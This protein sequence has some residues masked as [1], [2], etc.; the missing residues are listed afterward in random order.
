VTTPYGSRAEG[1]WNDT[2]VSSHTNRSFHAHERAM[3]KA[4]HALHGTTDTRGSIFTP[5]PTPENPPKRYC[6][7]N[8][9]KNYI[10]LLFERNKSGTVDT[11]PLHIRNAAFIPCLS[12]QGMKAAEVGKL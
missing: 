4:T 12:R 6:V 3:L 9:Q 1:F 8:V 11:T 10:S 7:A 2:G 5:G